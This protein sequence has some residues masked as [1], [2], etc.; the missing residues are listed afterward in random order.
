MKR[1]LP[2]FRLLRSFF[3]RVACR[4]NQMVIRRPA[5]DWVHGL[6]MTGQME[7]LTPASAKV[8]GPV[9]TGTARVGHPPLPSE[10][11]EAF[12]LF[13]DVQQRFRSGAL[14]CETRQRVGKMTGKDQSIRTHDEMT[15]A[16]SI[17]AGAWNVRIVIRRDEK[18]FHPASKS[19]SCSMGDASRL[20]ELCMGRAPGVTMHEGPAQILSIRESM[21]LGVQLFRQRTDVT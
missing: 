21:S 4:V 12:R 16:P 10:A 9:G 7:R 5:A 13:P 8:D 15:A 14:E 18:N 3:R 19:F 2:Q 6:Q 1:S 20:F 17:H 11:I